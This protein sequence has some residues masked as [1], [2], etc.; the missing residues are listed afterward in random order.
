M[1]SFGTLSFFV[2]ALGSTMSSSE[3]PTISPR[4][5]Y[6]EDLHLQY[7][8]AMDVYSYYSSRRMTVKEYADPFKADN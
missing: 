7:I 1:H 6:A 2:I 4:F 8:Y 5:Y 3:S